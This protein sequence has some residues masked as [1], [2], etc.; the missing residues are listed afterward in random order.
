M[1]EEEI[2]TNSDFLPTGLFL[3][4][5][6]DLPNFCHNTRTSRGSVT[7]V[8]GVFELMEAFSGDQPRVQ[9]QSQMI[10]CGDAM[11]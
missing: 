1:V 9:K 6:S 7:C 5:G 4:P 10:K 8:E 3:T 11:I 2:K